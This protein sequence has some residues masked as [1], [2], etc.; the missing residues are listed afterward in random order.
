MFWQ[1]YQLSI[2]WLLQK[3]R[4]PPV[5]ASRSFKIVQPYNADTFT[6]LCPL[7]VNSTKQETY[8]HITE[9]EKSICYRN[10]LIHVARLHGPRPAPELT[11][12]F[13]QTQITDRLHFRDVFCPAS[14][15]CIRDT[16]LEIHLRRVSAIPSRNRP[17]I[18]DNRWWVLTVALCLR[19]WTQSF[20]RVDHETHFPC[21]SLLC[22]LFRGVELRWIDSLVHLVSL[23][24]PSILEC[25]LR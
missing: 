10:K 19:V 3:A 8:L 4:T 16:R 7:H 1:L 24:K 12:A 18:T 13:C 2:S 5:H 15:P 11:S 23:V 20:T 21:I 9:K 14:C 17:T 22:K 6:L 25:V